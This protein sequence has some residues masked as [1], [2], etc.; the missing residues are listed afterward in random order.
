MN[1]DDA[2]FLDA[3]AEIT[4]SA[5]L[6]DDT[7][8][9][10]G[11]GAILVTHRP[12]RHFSD[13]LGTV[14]TAPSR[15]LVFDSDIE[16]DDNA[17]LDAAARLRHV[18]P[19]EA[20]VFWQN[21]LNRLASDRL[22]DL[23]GVGTLTIENGAP[24]LRFL[25]ILQHAVNA[26]YNG[27]VDLGLSRSAAAVEHTDGA[28]REAAAAN[29]VDYVDLVDRVIDEQDTA[30][31][32][33]DHAVPT[34]SVAT[35]SLDEWTPIEDVESALD[36]LVDNDAEPAVDGETAPAQAAPTEEATLAGVVEDV[37]THSVTDADTDA[38]TDIIT[39]ADTAIITGADAD[40]ITGADTDTV[41]GA[42]TAPSMLDAEATLDESGVGDADAEAHRDAD[43]SVGATGNI[44]VSDDLESEGFVA[45]ESDF[46]IPSQDA[47]ADYDSDG[48]SASTLTDEAMASG[49]LPAGLEPET[50]QT[51]V[52]DSETALSSESRADVHGQV[53][54]DHFDPGS[55]IDGDD[56]SYDDSHA[57]DHEP[58][59]VDAHPEDTHSSS[60]S[61]SSSAGVSSDAPVAEAPS[62]AS[63]ETKA[64]TAQDTAEDTADDAGLD[65]KSTDRS[66]RE[67]SRPD[68]SR[69]SRRSR[70]G[71]AVFA[72]VA[73]LIAA[74]ALV[75]WLMGWIGT[76]TSDSPATTDGPAVAETVEPP[77]ESESAELPDAGDANPI[78]DE[79]TPSPPAPAAAEP[80]FQ[81]GAINLASGGFTIIVSSKETLTEA[82]DAA[83]GLGERTEPVDILEAQVDGQTRYRV[84]VGQ[85]RTFSLASRAL[86]QASARLPEGSWIGRIE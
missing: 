81:R 15:E 49:A 34:A 57:T 48:S 78:D 40:T 3:F 85:Y 33:P 69:M 65:A 12:S 59:A 17:T 66:P 25:P 16:L 84:A 20:N 22:L 5:V 47:S 4:R 44:D 32:W 53:D 60:S 38:D 76:R 67:R 14:V 13:A 51:A 82:V 28:A 7:V 52:S 1:R 56:D 36:D 73:V 41:S 37:D 19:A 50:I 23:P 58:E 31:E 63:D 45:L 54:V 74:V 70:S 26:R 61:S 55:H 42:G 11:L 18:T 10:P 29:E 8:T 75:A 86:N 71:S 72:V 39:S 21:A 80:E 46:I 79:G 43:A 6:A 68:R 62:D 64:D 9:L 77:A 35:G 24:A 30:E 27:Y 83:L 2:Q